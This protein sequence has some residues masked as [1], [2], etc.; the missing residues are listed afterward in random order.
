MVALVDRL[1][2]AIPADYLPTARYT[3]AG[4]GIHRIADDYL[5]F[6]RRDRCHSGQR[7][8]NGQ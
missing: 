6:E 2:V 7:E 3:G 1:A 5:R 4:A 8:T